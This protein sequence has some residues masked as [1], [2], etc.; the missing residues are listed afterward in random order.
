VVVSTGMYRQVESKRK[1]SSSEIPEIQT[2][3][4]RQRDLQRNLENENQRECR[5]SRY[6]EC[7]HREKRDQ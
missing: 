5:P 3:V 7:T 4:C 2:Q 6:A 1:P